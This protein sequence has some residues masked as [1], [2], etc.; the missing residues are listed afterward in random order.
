ML[1]FS[2]EATN[3][4]QKLKTKMMILFQDDESKGTE[5]VWQESGFIKKKRGELTISKVNFPKN[6]LVY[7][8]QASVSV[9]KDG[10]Q[11]IYVEFLVIGQLMPVS[12]PD[13]SINLETNLETN[14]ALLYMPVYNKS[15]GLYSGLTK[16]LA[17]IT[18]RGDNNVRFY[19]YN[20]SKENSSLLYFT[21]KQPLPNISTVWPS[22]NI[23]GFFL[24]KIKIG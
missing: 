3:K 21:M 11:A 10:E 16:K 2:K 24:M 13:P 22:R 12:N 4:D 23:M 14:E 1:Y 7:A 19:S 8:N 18:L 5:K 20:Y 17:S 15:T 9:C 6:T